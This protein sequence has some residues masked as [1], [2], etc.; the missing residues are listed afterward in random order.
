[1]NA[2]TATIRCVKDREGTI[3]TTTNGILQIFHDYWSNL[4]SHAQD[5]T[6][7]D[8]FDV[9]AASMGEIPEI[10]DAEITQKEVENALK[11][12][13]PN[14]SMGLDD[15][16]PAFLCDRSDELVQALTLVFND[17]LS[18]GQFPKQWKTDRRIAL[19]KNN[20]KSIVSNYRLLAIHSVFRKIFC[21]IIHDRIRT[22][23]Q[24][25]DA[26]S[27]FRKN[28][29]GTD[30]ALMLSN[31]ILERAANEGAY[32][33]VVDF[34]KAF[35]RCHIATLLR[36]LAE[37]NVKGSLLRIIKNM[38][39]DCEAQLS[40]NGKTGPAFKV[41]RGVAQGCVLSPLFFDVYLDDLLNKFREEGLGIPTGQ[42]VHRASSFA[43]D[44][45]LLA[46]N[47]KAAERYLEI[48]DRWCNENFF[49]IN[50]KKS[51]ILRVGKLRE[52]P[53]PNLSLNGERIRLLEEE[54]PVYSNVERFKYLGFTIPANGKW[55]EFI[56]LQT[57]RCRQAFG[58]YWRFF[59]LANVSVDLKLRAAHSLIFSHL[60]YGED[61]ICLTSQ[62]AR[63]IDSIQAKVI[64]AILQLP[65]ETNND[66]VRFMTG[67]I[68]CSSI[69]EVR[70]LTNLQ[71]IRNLPNDTQLKKVYDEKLWHK[72]P[73]IFQRYEE[74]ERHICAKSRRTAF[75]SPNLQQ[76]LSQPPDNKSKM[77]LKSINSASEK[78]QV[79][80]RLRLNHQDLL[81]GFQHTSSHPMWRRPAPSLRIYNRWIMGC[82]NA[83][84]DLLRHGKGEPM[85]C[86]LCDS[87]ELE[88]RE[89][90]LTECDGT[91]DEATEFINEMC[92]IS[93]QK[94]A[95]FHALPTRQ[96]RAAWMLAG[97]SCKATLPSS[98]D[99]YR[100][101]PQRSP[102]KQGT[103][104][105]PV[106]D[107]KDPVQ[108][109]H[110]YIDYQHILC[111]LPHKHI[112]IYTDGSRSTNTGISGY[113]L[114]ILR[115]DEDSAQIIHEQSE[116]LGNATIQQAELSAIRESLFCIIRN[117]K[118]SDLP[119]H[120]FTDSKYCYNACTAHEIRRKNFYLLQEIQHFAH[121]L[122]LR[123]MPCTIH[124]LPSHIENTLIG[125]RY[126]GNYHADLLALDGQ[127]FSVSQ[128]AEKQL[129]TVRE[130]LLTAVIKFVESIERKLKL[131]NEQPN[132]PPAHADDLSAPTDAD[133]NPGNR[134]P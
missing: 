14:K 20:G 75:N 112:R 38:Y 66:A 7:I 118:L 5:Q 56:D 43:D 123:N 70:S 87:K 24:L 41:T 22:F 85:Y 44:L 34:S 72:R 64:K 99:S 65:K 52:E 127:A 102:I 69:R 82:S 132:G 37:K 68:T 103:S 129:H 79:S 101:T 94:Y 33:I 117:R 32:V 3:K 49:K 26:Q 45:A 104:V 29:R 78:A 73:F 25:D 15:I 86:R 53:D 23:L 40:I 16:S 39:T 46:A 35:D 106:K 98:I 10:C 1:M 9:D 2:T 12:V 80:H 88:S 54:D 28:R 61:I 71:R 55:D 42:V 63:K 51:G 31:I 96:S 58:R 83:N 11:Q 21:S 47:K 30:N 89:H 27:G 111:S 36:K 18:S 50:A 107:K 124:W 17:V 59:R 13:S 121:W 130:R 81:L 76:M 19:Y 97:G 91:L 6:D 133:R 77:L 105:Q 131:L 84:E 90:L 126:T 109:Y 128:D 48:L 67:Q 92:E 119:I 125:K 120:I 122:Q 113:G 8:N 114:R 4:F 108:C 74:I 134:V 62:Q 116:G 57:K 93:M 110:A 115:Q 60:A 95:E 100:I